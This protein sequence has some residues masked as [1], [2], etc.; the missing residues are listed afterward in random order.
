MLHRWLISS[1][2]LLSM[3]VGAG[4][5][6]GDLIQLKD[7]K[8]ISGSVK[9]N[10]DVMVITAD[11]G[12]V[13]TVKP[14]DVV[15]VTL[16]STVTPAQAAESE[17]TRVA[18]QVRK[19]E[20]LAE[21]IT[22]HEK[23]LEKNGGTPTAA[24]VRKS[25]DE[26]KKLQLQDGVR[27]RSRWMPRAQAEVML[28]LDEENARPAVGNYKAGRMKEAIDSANAAIKQDDENVTA[29]AIGGLAAYRM[30]NLGLS[31]QFFARLG[32]V[33]ASSVLGLNNAA[34]VCFQQKREAESLLFYARAL[35]AS[36]DNRL[37][38]DN[39][40]EA[41][42]SY[43]GAKDSGAYKNL[44]RQ[45]DQA[46]V[47]L[48]ASMAKKNQFRF[49]STWVTQEQ[50]DRL[51]AQRKAILDAM[52]ELDSHYKAA[53][54]AV[55]TMEKDIRQAAADYDST[56]GDVNYLSLLILSAQQRNEDATY[57][58]NQ[59]DVQLFN[60]ERIR[61]RKTALEDQH[62]KLTAS[63]KA[64][65]VEAERLKTQ[66]AGA[67]MQQFTGIQRIM[68]LGEDE[69]PPAPTA[70]TLPPKTGGGPGSPDVKMNPSISAAN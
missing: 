52:T 61:R 22:L 4:N 60:L 3:A 16:T 53:Q 70:V 31:R 46:E 33:D 41:M 2:A 39:I 6:Y 62:A 50:L 47:R 19:A 40:M 11:D 42:N 66:L 20:S 55:S 68:E 17:W 15:R 18:S 57:L 67:A 48:E 25:L 37:L 5:I 43:T 1:A 28:R 26:Y 13:Q 30:N 21:V 14:D 38:L 9:R 23:F 56:L 35:S 32:D 36:A 24:E 54:V 7:G 29:L 59:R 69:N 45:L 27:F 44:A 64:Y 12:T 8:T 49:G 34:V 58:L 65:Q 10:G 51:T 63:F